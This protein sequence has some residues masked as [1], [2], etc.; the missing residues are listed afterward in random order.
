M[1]DQTSVFEMLRLV[2]LWSS[3]V[4]LLVGLL[5]ILYANYKRLEEF[6]GKELFGIKKKVFPMFETNIYVF[7]EWLLEKKTILGVICIIIAV[8]FF[9]EFRK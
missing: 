9:F 4:I 8:L 7:H 6:F 3:P 2:L 1:I 5:L